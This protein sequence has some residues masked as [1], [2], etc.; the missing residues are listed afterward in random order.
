[1]SIAK[2]HEGWQAGADVDQRCIRPAGITR[3]PRV[4][5]LE[6][7]NLWNSRRANGSMCNRRGEVDYGHHQRKNDERPEKQASSKRSQLRDPVSHH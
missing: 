1:M 7:P 4:P 6:H 5:R 2:G 3:V